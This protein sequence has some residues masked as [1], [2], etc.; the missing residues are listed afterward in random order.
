MSGGVEAFAI[1]FAENVR[2]GRLSEVSEVGGCG[3]RGVGG[4]GVGVERFVTRGRYHLGVG[5][6]TRAC[7]LDGALAR[8]GLATQPASC[9]R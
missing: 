6:C 7:E 1:V 3:D 4:G 9:L 8:F 5:R 2:T